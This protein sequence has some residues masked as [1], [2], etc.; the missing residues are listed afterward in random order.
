MSAKRRRRTPGAVQRVGRRLVGVGRWLIGHPQSLLF[1]V[2]LTVV[3]W[4]LWAYAQQ[5]DAFRVA[6]VVTPPGVSFTLPEP[7]IGRPVWAVDIRTLAQALSRQQPTLKQ[8]HVI[9]QLPNVIRIEAIPRM[10]VAEVRV[11]SSWYPVDEDGF[12][13]PGKVAESAAPSVR[14]VLSDRGGDRLNV[15]KGNTDERLRLALRV[16]ARLRHAPP[17]IT[18]SLT[19]INV[20]DP[21]QIRFVLHN[22]TEIRCGPE[23]ELDTHLERLRIVMHVVTQ[24]A[25]AA[26]YVD[27]RFP[28]PVIGPRS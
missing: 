13:L 12:I 28:Q 3:G 19:E 21:Q 18:R 6:S 10:P 1:T 4:A 15:G 24:Q 9:R 23:A 8:I 16:F 7:L 11:D 14:L 2:A 27:V 20:S 17:A 22:D 5:A 26:K 25:G